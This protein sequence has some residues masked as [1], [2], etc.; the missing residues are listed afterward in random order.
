MPKFLVVGYQTLLKGS[1]PL[2]L[3]FSIHEIRRGAVNTEAQ[4]APKV[5][6]PIRR[7]VERAIGGRQPERIRLHD[8]VARVKGSLDEVGF[9]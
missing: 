5:D 7:L 3:R 2:F 1:I 8:D 4:C 6:D 9:V